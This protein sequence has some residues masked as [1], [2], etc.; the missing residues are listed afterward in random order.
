[1]DFTSV[2]QRAD[3]PGFRYN[4]MVCPS[5]ALSVLLIYTG[6][7]YSLPSLRSEEAPLS[8]AEVPICGA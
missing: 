7:N 1:M 6:Y 3:I 4:Y 8:E 2:K 5:I